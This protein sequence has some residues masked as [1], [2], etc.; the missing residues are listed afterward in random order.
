LDQS[1]G[2]SR[3]VTSFSSFLSKI[4]E[5][6]RIS[7]TEFEKETDIEKRKQIIRSMLRTKK[8][9]PLLYLDDYETVSFDLNKQKVEKRHKPSADM[10]QIAHF[11]NK[12]IPSNTSILLTSRETNNGLAGET[13]LEV[14]GLEENESKELFAIFTRSVIGDNSYNDKEIQT[15]IDGII[16]MTSGHPLSLEIIASNI[17]SIYDIEKVAN[18]IQIEEDNVYSPDERLRSLQACFDY[19]VNRLNERLKSL[20]LNLTMFHSPF[21]I[22]APAKIFGNNQDDIVQSQPS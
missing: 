16:K 8:H 7:I 19:T 9:H 6:L 1:S 21:P 3:G 15:A 18:E 17:D 14:K 13:S 2:F 4:A 11:L 5:S 22:D 12:E 10:L 20:L